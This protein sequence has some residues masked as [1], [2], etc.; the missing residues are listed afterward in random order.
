MIHLQLK[1]PD[2]VIGNTPE[3]DSGDSWFESLL[4]N[5]KTP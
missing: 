1:L 4:G 5:K 3:S 2:S